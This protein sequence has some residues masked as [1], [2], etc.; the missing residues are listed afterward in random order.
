MTH[1]CPKCG[2]GQS[3][4]TGGVCTLDDIPLRAISDGEDRLVGRLIDGRF[5]LVEVLGR[6]GSGVV[7]RAVQLPI[8][9]EVAVKVISDTIH[10][11]ENMR[12]RFFR[13]ARLASSLRHP[14]IVS[15]V[16]FGEDPEQGVVFFAM[17]YV[18]GVDLRDLL[19]GHRL[20]LP[21]AL[22]ILY[23]SCGALIDAHDK[24]IIHRDLKPR[25]IRLVAVCD[26][27]MQVKVLDLGIARPIESQETITK[28]GNIAGTIA[29]L[30]PEYIEG[31][32]LCSGSDLY[33]LGIIFFEMLT[34]RK[35]FSGNPLQM[36]FH[37]M[38]TPP[39]RVDAY[40][41]EV[42]EEIEV[43]VALLLEKSP[44]SRIESARAIRSRID[45]IRLG[46]GLSRFEIKESEASSALESFSPWVEDVPKDLPILPPAPS[47][48]MDSMRTVA[49]DLMGRKSALPRGQKLPPPFDNSHLVDKKRQKAK[50]QWHESGLLGIDEVVRHSRAQSPTPPMGLSKKKI[51]PF[52]PNRE[53]V[54]TLPNTPPVMKR[55][56]LE[57]L[58]KAKPVVEEPVVEKGA[59][60][61]LPPLPELRGRLSEHS[62]LFDG[63]SDDDRGVEVVEEEEIQW[64]TWEVGGT[65]SVEREKK[66]GSPLGVT[67]IGALT[68]LIALAGVLSLF[69]GGSGSGS[70]EPEFDEYGEADETSP[71]A[72]I[73]ERTGEERTDVDAGVNGEALS[74]R[75]DKAFAD[76]EMALHFLPEEVPEGDGA[77]RSEGDGEESNHRRNRRRRARVAEGESAGEVEARNWQAVHELIERAGRP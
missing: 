41:V 72:V 65:S 64:E 38:N 12:E 32:R 70:Y 39:P 56:D 62:G 48:I 24:G 75:D 8:G 9:R 5:R 19:N 6:G 26:G 57:E 16:D 54:E 4:E 28:S 15:P 45:E 10:F 43:L 11:D 74:L 18:A 25:N 67:I 73:E 52:R 21:L 46:Y 1:Y 68:F 61:Q 22:E 23:Q 66:V 33:A 37:H 49:A 55:P 34:G 76:F 13:E 71:S 30:A 40:G 53:A 77:E 44:E 7:Y 20:R 60:R 35:P 3:C 59:S 29:Y 69:M 2:R 36:M 27:S 50:Q 47:G 17:E 14:N 31:G 51:P 42:P 63:F 58:S